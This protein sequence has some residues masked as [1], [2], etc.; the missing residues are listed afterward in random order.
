MSAVLAT[1][2]ADIRQRW[3]AMVVLG[4]VVA[5]AATAITSAAALARRT[6]TAFDRRLDAVHAADA[7]LGAERVPM[8]SFATTPAPSL[9][10]LAGVHSEERFGGTLL[11]FPGVPG[12]DAADQLDGAGLST[13][14]LIALDDPRE[15]DLEVPFVISGRLPNWNSPDEIFVSPGIAAAAGWKPGSRVAMQYFDRLP[16]SS[17]PDEPPSIAGLEAVAGRLD[18]TVAGIGDYAS[19]YATG[20]PGD[21]LVLVTPKF[22]EVHRPIAAVHRESRRADGEHDRAAGDR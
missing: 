13:I 1:L 20:S 15:G 9:A 3:K 18:V 11:F 8:A 6:S 2:R 7:W 16:E 12:L 5:L 19:R 17:R 4:L 10:G 14:Q 21:E 22:S